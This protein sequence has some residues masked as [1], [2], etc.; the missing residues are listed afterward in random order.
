MRKRL[1][2]TKPFLSLAGASLLLL[3]G[4]GP[5]NRAL[6]TAVSPA[7]SVVRVT[8]TI[9]YPDLQRP[10]LRKQPFTRMGLGTVIA[11][12]RLLVTADLVAHSTYIE[13][14]RPE[15]GPK[16][17]ARIEALDEECN[18]AVLRPDDPGTLRESRPLALETGAGTGSLLDILQLEPNGAAALTPA[19]VTT[20]A[21]MPY[22]ADG[23]S[24]LLYR[25]A[26]SI[27]QREGSF[28]LPA[29]LHG[30]LAGLVM[31][32]DARVQTAEIIP[33]P[34]IARFLKESAKPE[35]H[36]LARAGLTW[37][38]VRGPNLREWLGAGNEKGGV[39]IDSVAPDG[40]AERAGLQ[41]GDLLL[42]A[43]GR[44]VDGE[45]NY[46]DSRYGKT[47][48]SNLASVESAPGDPMEVTYF[49]SSG[50]GTGTLGTTTLTL[51]GRRSSSEISPSRLEG[52]TP[53]HRFL[54][55]FLFQELSRPYLQE[56]GQNWRTEAPQNLLYLDSFQ[57]EFPRNQG[58]F[59]ILSAVLPSPQTIGYQ[60]LS[61][62]VVKRINGRS[63]RCL[64]DVAAAADHPEGGFHRIELEGATGP[65]FLDAGNLP[66]EEA[67]IRAHYGIP[68]TSSPGTR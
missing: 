34:L 7:D 51:S 42:K 14:E 45:G 52:Q 47:T 2:V 60:D 68:E 35:F 1:P 17:T 62:R 3:A 18:L 39:Y 67:K 8:A 40:P 32:Y 44:S 54:G 11:D 63:I 58:R 56:W 61:N 20:V 53:P 25:A 41:R 27:P 49:R 59:V 19:T 33:A 26:T 37:E 55:G 16:T 30:K 6:P 31:R 57:E 28:V 50:E 48:F 43:A 4:C 66:E 15:D 64:A 5:L 9:Q 38:E 13:L 29:L 24:Y 22:P 12:G 21:V 46:A 65:I 10:W 36:G 23:A